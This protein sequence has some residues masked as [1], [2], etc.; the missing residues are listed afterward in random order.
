MQQLLPLQPCKSATLQLHWRRIFAR[1][2]SIYYRAGMPGLCVFGAPAICEIRV[3]DHVRPESRCVCAVLHIDI[4]APA[5]TR[6]QVHAFLPRVRQHVLALKV[7]AL[8]RAWLDAE[9]TGGTTTG[10]VAVK[11]RQFLRQH[12]IG[13]LTP[14]GG[15]VP[16][17]IHP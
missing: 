8:A 14:N 13:I 15:P 11:G 1:T 10:D 9:A 2:A 17:V 5:L 6:Q 7:G 3:S 4:V 16:G 12:H